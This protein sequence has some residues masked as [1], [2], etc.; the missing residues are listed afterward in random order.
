MVYDLQKAGLWKRISAWLFDG[1]LL[2]ILAVGFAWGLSSLLGYQQYNTAVDQAYAKYEARY[3]V[4]FSI[5]EEAYHAMPE[6]YQQRYT[7]AYNA[8]IADSDAMYQYNMMLN[9]TLVILTLGILLAMVVLEFLVPLA[10]GDG[11]TL[12]KRIFG[13]CLVRTDGVKVNT[14]QLFARTILGKF[15]IE[16]MI[17]VYMVTLFFLG[18]LGLEGTLAVLLLGLAQILILIFSRTNALIHD[19]LAGT[20]VADRS[21]QMIFPSTEALIECKKKIAAEQAAR[22]AY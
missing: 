21:S 5:S 10:L 1:I 12:G 7:D 15:A 17:P 9:L 11:Q 20:A 22:Q 3:D 13:L 6:D 2:T 14:M 8:L 16:T 19:L 4:S 18:N